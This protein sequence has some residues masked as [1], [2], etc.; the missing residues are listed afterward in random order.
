MILWASPKSTII[1]SREIDMLDQILVGKRAEGA[2][3]FKAGTPIE[4]CP[5]LVIP[6]MSLTA[7]VNVQEWRAGWYFAEAEKN[8]G[9]VRWLK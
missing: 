7:A 4:E 8:G 2:E 9:Q 3:A 5:Y 6:Y 1:G